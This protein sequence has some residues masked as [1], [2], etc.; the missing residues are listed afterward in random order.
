MLHLAGV[1][2]LFLCV[3]TPVPEHPVKKAFTSSMG[4]AGMNDET[5][6]I[7]MKAD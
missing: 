3:H 4:N 6:V 5:V 7:E 1:V 2:G